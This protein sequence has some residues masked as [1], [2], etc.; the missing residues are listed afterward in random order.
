[1]HKAGQSGE[2]VSLA[3]VLAMTMRTYRELR[4]YSIPAIDHALAQAVVL[5]TMQR[6]A[7]LTGTQPGESPAPGAVAE[8]LHQVLADLRDEA[9]RLM[10]SRAN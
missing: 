4:G 7:M 3:E 2:Q 9:L 10:K 5:E 1:M 8:I 6:T